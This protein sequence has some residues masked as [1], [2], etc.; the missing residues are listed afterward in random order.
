MDPIITYIK[1]GNLPADPSKAR[2]I[3][4]RSSKFTILNDELYKRGFLQTYLKCLNLEDAK[5]VL[6]EI[7]EG[8]CGNHFGPRSL[9]GQVVC[10]GYFWP[11]IQKGA[12]QVI[13]RYDKCQQFG[14]A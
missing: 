1:D 11:T 2:K 8:V 5:Y 9:I 7:H 12:T 3:K 6:R 4:V 14:N 13:Q 10:V